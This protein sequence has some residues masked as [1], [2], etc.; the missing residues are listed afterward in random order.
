MEYHTLDFTDGI[1]SFLAS[2][3]FQPNIINMI[4]TTF[5]ISQ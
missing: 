1:L 5:Y 3:N 4:I 2:L